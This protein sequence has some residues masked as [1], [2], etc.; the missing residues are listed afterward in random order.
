VDD[1]RGRCLVV[2][3]GLTASEG[4]LGRKVSLKVDAN[5]VFQVDLGQETISVMPTY[6]PS[7][8]LFNLT[9]RKGLKEGIG[10]A[11]G[12]CGITRTQSTS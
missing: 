12:R 6:H 10:L 3:L 5:K 1:L 8:C 11:M 7:A 9:A 2:A 4:L